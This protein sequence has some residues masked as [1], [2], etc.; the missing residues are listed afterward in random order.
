VINGILNDPNDINGVTDGVE[1]YIESQTP[2]RCTRYEYRAG[3]IT[4]HIMQGSRIRDVIEICKIHQDKEII[5]IAHSYGCDIVCGVLKKSRVRIEE[6][7]LFCAATEC[8]FDKNGINRAVNGQ[9]LQG[10]NLYGSRH[11]KAL[12]KAKKMSFLKPLG[13]GFGYLGLDGPCN[14]HP[15]VYPKLNVMW[16]DNY[17][18]NT[19]LKSRNLKSTL[20]IV[21]GKNL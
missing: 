16:K 19:W 15:D 8:D 2:Y 6:V 3:V 20:D 21:L 7:H 9:R 18:H 12:Q 1:N 5:L 11:D 13:I 14:V 4:A 10:V 17:D